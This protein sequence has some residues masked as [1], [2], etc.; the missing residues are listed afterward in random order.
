MNDKNTSPVL[1]DLKTLKGYILG[2]IA[3]ATTTSVFLTQALHFPADITLTGVTLCSLGA[4]LVGFLI[5]RSERRQARLFKKYIR[6]NTKL[7]SEFGES[8]E[9]LKLAT[10]ENQKASLRHELNTLMRDEP[11]NHDTILMYAEKYFLELNGGDW[12]ETDK[13]VA[14]ADGEI[15]AGRRVYIPPTLASNITERIGANKGEES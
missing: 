8:I 3:F 9:A 5:N 7:L 2:V 13:F 10:I 12:A 1:E 15:K 14:W 4:L 11:Y 6:E